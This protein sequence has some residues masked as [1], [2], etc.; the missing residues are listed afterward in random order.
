MTT[1]KNKAKSHLPQMPD[2]S[3]IRSGGKMK[4]PVKGTTIG[5]KFDM[6]PPPPPKGPH[7]PSAFDMGGIMRGSSQRR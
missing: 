3:M 7:I 5:P 2:N 1:S 6:T 4:M